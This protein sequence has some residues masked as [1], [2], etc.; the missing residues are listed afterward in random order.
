MRIAQVAPLYE[1]VPPKFY[2]G[3]ER[4]VS[5]LTETLH[6]FGHEV[7]LFASG[8]SRTRATL[9]KVVPRAL[10]LFSGVV[11]PLVSHMLLL[12]KVL[13]QREC[14]DII[15]FHCDYLHFP[16]SRLAN[17]PQLTT[18][19]GRL[20]IRDLYP[21]YKEFSEMPVVSISDRQRDPLPFANW[22]STV[23]HGLPLDLY[24]PGFSPG[25]YVA[26]LG[27]ISPEKGVEHAI[28]IARAVK[29]P[30]KV[31]A[32]IDMADRD[33]FIAKVEPHFQRPEVDYIGEINEVE[34]RQFLGRAKCLLF[35]IEWPE[36]F[37]LVMIEAL[38]CGTP[39][40]AFNRGSVSEIIEPGVTGF[41]AESVEEAIALYPQTIALDRQRVR[42]RFCE[43]FSA[44]CMARKYEALYERLLVAD[45]SREG[46]R[47][48]Q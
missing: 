25:N 12:Q 3:T 34:K 10:R 21:L 31:A 22:L 4:I 1:S 43:R 2:G 46:H 11:D 44:Q 41:I 39:V 42:Q 16:L 48:A 17:L 26:F 38:A 8:D 24:E 32:K 14:F 18:L 13:A 40:L 27:R 37:G 6:D 7:T 15:H 35:P 5:Y 28:N 9:V 30:L 47:H 36:P 29:T 19:H 45:T 20:D 33:Y 23:H